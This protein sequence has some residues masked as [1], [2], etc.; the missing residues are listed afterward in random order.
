M[1]KKIFIVNASAF[2]VYYDY[3]MLASFSKKFKEKIIYFTSD[4]RYEKLRFPSGIRRKNFFFK[5]VNFLGNYIHDRKVLKALKGIEY[6]IEIFVFIVYS[7]FI[8]PSTVH[9]IWF[10]FPAV[11]LCI[12]YILHTFGIKIIYTAHNA[13]PHDTGE[14]YKQLFKRIYIKVDLIVCLTEGEKELIMH[15]FGISSSKICIIPHGDYNFIMKN[16][17]FNKKLFEE[18]RI[19][20]NSKKIILFFGILRP[21]KGLHHLIEAFKLVLS[22]IT[23]VKLVIAGR[24]FTE[25]YRTT[26]LK[27]I[28]DLDLNEFVYTDLRYIPIEDLL[29]YLKIAYVGVL[30][31]IEASQSGNIITFYSVDIPVISTFA[32]ALPE[33]VEDGK[34]GLLVSPRDVNA[35]SDAI[36]YMLEHP[37]VRKK[38]VLGTGKL[39]REKFNWEKNIIKLEELYDY[40]E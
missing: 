6:I 15:L 31:Y 40:P 14:S 21:Y 29:A 4:Y 10:P 32:G 27:K 24:P 36:V 17:S 11:D 5:I 28:K 20:F 38:M 34:T 25:E 12:L 22:K 7:I 19:R 8:H 2:G 1:N 33:M 39:L 37:D 30:P 35:L 23:D 9:F 18:L 13:L 26:L 16:V 3:S